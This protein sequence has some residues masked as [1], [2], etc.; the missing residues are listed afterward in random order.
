MG[1]RGCPKALDS[2]AGSCGVA[3]VGRR[4]AT[5]RAG[6]LRLLHLSPAAWLQMVAELL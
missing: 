3:R 2:F 1:P 6:G 4:G 5:G